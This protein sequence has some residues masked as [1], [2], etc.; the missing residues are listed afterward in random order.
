MGKSAPIC[1]RAQALAL[2]EEGVTIDRI[3]ER[4][5]LAKS[6]IYKIKK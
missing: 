3:H 5:G 4:T 6:V 1:L 2:F